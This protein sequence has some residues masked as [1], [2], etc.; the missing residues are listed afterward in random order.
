MESNISRELIEMLRFALK[1]AEPYPIEFLDELKLDDPRFE[2]DNPEKDRINATL[3]K[4][5]LIEHGIAIDN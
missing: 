1:K 3:A 4:K 2:L 5:F